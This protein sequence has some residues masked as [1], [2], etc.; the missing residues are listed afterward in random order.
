MVVITTK[1][2]VTT[3]KDGEIYFSNAVTNLNSINNIHVL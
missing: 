3:T 1:V 2:L